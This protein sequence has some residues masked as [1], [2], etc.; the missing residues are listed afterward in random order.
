MCGRWELCAAS[1][2]HREDHAGAVH[3]RAGCHE[4]Y[5]VAVDLT[6]ASP[7]LDLQGSFSN[8]VHAVEVTLAK[9][10]AVRVYRESPFGPGTA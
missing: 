10:S 9:Q 5:F 8:S 4:T 7:A 1:S 3:E 2:V 6:V